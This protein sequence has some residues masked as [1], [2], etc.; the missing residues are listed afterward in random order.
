MQVK[1]MFENTSKRNLSVS[2][3]FF[4]AFAMIL[5]GVFIAT[6][7]TDAVGEDL[8]DTYGEGSTINIAPGYSYTY[9]ATFPSDLTEGV[10][11][12]AAVNDFSSYGS[13]YV[14]IDGHQV[15]VTIPSNADAG[16]YNLVL[17]ATHAASGQTAYQYIIFNVG[18][19]LS[20][21]GTINDIIAGASVD[22]TPSASGGVGEITWAVN[23]SLP[24]GLSWDGTKVT[25]TPTGVGELTVSLTA[26][27]STG[28]SK[29]LDITF[30]VWNAIVGGEPETITSIG[31]TT[32]SSTGISNGS[33]IGVTWAVS[34][35]TLPEG[36]SLD[37]STGVVSGH[38]TSGA[39]VDTTVTITGTAANGPS[40]TATK[41]ITIHAEPAFTLSGT[42]SSILTYVSNAESKT[43]TV[44]P[45]ATTSD[46][47]WS[48][49]E[50]TGVSIDAGVLTVTGSA[51]PQTATDLTVTA[52]TEYGQVQTFQ[53]SLTVEDTLTISGDLT[54]TGTVGT[55]ATSGVFVISGG[56]NNQLQASGLEGATISEGALSVTS[57]SPVS[58][59]EVTITVT[60]AAGQTA[61]HT[62]T[63]TI[64]NQLVFDSVPSNGV[65][66]FAV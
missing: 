64:F 37:A 35:G 12:T 48:V 58:A 49:T 57:A 65:I 31:T 33:D 56:S 60:S 55:P 32:A 39:V 24:E 15:K 43:V 41:Q 42:A 62:I 17:Q 52:T 1:I 36:F 63:V 53:V 28:E 5:A 8:S 46:I 14:Q 25:G 54:L 29:D 2:M 50:A 61:Q 38:S 47:T 20:V 21:S 10:V 30:T 19:N 4:A 34:E 66:A 18:Q 44:S 16:L 3:A 6:E 45:S 13:Q 51:T 59:T 11:L 7:Q 22:M 23:G 27:T 40:Q 9:T 26:T